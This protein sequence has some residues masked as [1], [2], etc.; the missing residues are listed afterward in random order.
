MGEYL[1]ALAVGAIC[2][3]LYILRLNWVLSHTPQE[4]INRA[5]EP[6][7]RDYV[8]DVFERVKRDGI[9]WEDRLPP[10]KDRRYIVVGGSGFLG[11]QIILHLLVMGT[12]PEAIRIF[13]CASACLL[14]EKTFIV[15]QRQK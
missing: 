15:E 10:R 1:L 13:G 6:L 11:G 14:L 8:R 9:D 7:T 5:G 3:V 4:V 12:P 2:L